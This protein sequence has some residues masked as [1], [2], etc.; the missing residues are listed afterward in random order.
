MLHLL[1]SN[2]HIETEI[3]T[4]SFNTKKEMNANSPNIC[5]KIQ[6]N[7]TVNLY[8]YVCSFNIFLLFKSSFKCF[9]LK[10]KTSY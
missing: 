3:L 5:N 9:N 2:Y 10:S 1:H 4:I 7:I 6:I 8:Q